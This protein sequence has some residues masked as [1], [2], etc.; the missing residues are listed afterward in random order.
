[1][2]ERALHSLPGEPVQAFESLYEADRR[3][4]EVAG[5]AVALLG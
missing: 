3:A 1:V 2:I 4:R 5:E